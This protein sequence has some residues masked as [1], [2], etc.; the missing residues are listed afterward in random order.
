MLRREREQLY[1][2]MTRS[3]EELHVLETK[4]PPGNYQKQN[5][6][7]L[8]CV[9]IELP[10][11]IQVANAV[12]QEIHRQYKEQDG[13]DQKARAAEEMRKKERAVVE[14]VEKARAAEE[15]RRAV[16]V[17]RQTAAQA[18]SQRAA[19]TQQQTAAEA[20]EQAAAAR[21]KD[22]KTEPEASA[23]Q[24]QW[25]GGCPE[26]EDG[27]RLLFLQ[28]IGGKE[29]AASAE[30]DSP[31]AI[32]GKESE[33]SAKDSLDGTSK[34]ST[35]QARASAGS[36]C[37]PSGE[38]R[39]DSELV[40]ATVQMSGLQSRRDL[41][42]E[43]GE[44]TSYDHAKD[45]YAVR[46]QGSG[47]HILLKEASL[48]AQGADESAASPPD[49]RRISAASPP[50]AAL[51]EKEAKESD[52]VFEEQLVALKDAKEA[53]DI[54]VIEYAVALKR[55]RDGRRQGAQAAPAASSSGGGTPATQP[56]G[57]KALAGAKAE[58]K[59]AAKAKAAEEDDDDMG[60]PLGETVAFEP[61]RASLRSVT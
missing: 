1:E 52:D 14:M 36:P 28:A 55:L 34:G 41:N 31:Q 7:I 58:A 54:T 27:A 39:S 21:K 2:E 10:N 48:R 49:L 16:Q 40:G 23:K 29:S 60:E 18:D 50:A 45:R 56:V 59:A 32:G 13:E 17:N 4:V 20:G 25:L 53:G 51:S 6:K 22:L 8:E 42:G 43:L 47:E 5:H 35:E 12:L 61:T 24:D 46:I 30:E 15:M 37:S 33:A 9:Q 3:C 57:T 11:Q 44:V 26:S 38:T 19:E